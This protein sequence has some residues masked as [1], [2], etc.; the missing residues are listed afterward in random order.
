MGGW[1][2]LSNDDAHV[3]KPHEGKSLPQTGRAKGRRVDGL[4]VG[5]K[6]LAPQGGWEEGGVEGDEGHVLGGLDEDLGG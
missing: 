1:V 4:E 2:Y 5:G 3:L 6:V